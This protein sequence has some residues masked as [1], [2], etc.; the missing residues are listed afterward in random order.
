MPDSYDHNDESVAVN[1]VNNS[2]ISYADAVVAWH[3]MKF[4][5]SR[6]KGIG[7]ES[8]NLW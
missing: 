8:N 1:P 7:L 5:V 3:S 6:R 4:L 2:V